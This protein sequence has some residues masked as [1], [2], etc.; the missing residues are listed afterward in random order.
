MNTLL[1]SCEGVVIGG[2]SLPAIQLHTRES[3]CLHLPGP[4]CGDEEAQLLRTLTGGDLVPGVRVL[5]RIE[6]AYP[7]IGRTGFLGL[8]RQ[9][10]PV[11]WLRGAGVDPQNA[12][13]IVAR[14][15]LKSEWR[16]CNLPGNPRA[17]LGLE[18][19]WARGADAVVF[20]TVGLDPLGVQ[21]VFGAVRSH[22]QACAAIYLSYPYLTQGRYECAHLPGALC[23]DVAKS[24][25]GA[26][27]PFPA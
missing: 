2:Q 9:P 4:A 26:A 13:Q 1:L 15:G 3:L 12:A 19:V 10:Y 23:L 17:L 21:A 5:G 7:A 18:A 20:S 25:G 27:L 24:A 16:V 8:F 22:I 14:L 6:F 11:D